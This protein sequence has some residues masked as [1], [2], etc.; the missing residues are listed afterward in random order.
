M[1]AMRAFHTKKSGSGAPRPFSSQAAR[2]RLGKAAR[3]AYYAHTTPWYGGV[4]PR[5][6]P[7]FSI[8]VP[9][10][11]YARFLPETIRSLAAQEYD[12]ME[13]VIVNDGSPDNTE[14]VALGLVAEKAC[15]NLRYIRQENQGPAS[16]RNTGIAATGGQWV[17]S[18][19]SDDILAPGF[20]H[21]VAAYLAENDDVDAVSGAYRE[22]GARQ[23]DWKLTR[24][25]PERFLIQGNI[26]HCTVHRRSLWEAVGGYSP[27]N[28]WGGED[29]HFW[30]KCQVRGFRFAALPVPML[31]YRIHEGHSRFR[32]ATLGT[33]WP[34][35]LAMHHT[36]TP[37]AYPPSTLRAAHA[38]LLGMSPECEAAIR[39]NLRRLP[40]L[41]APRFWLGLA[42]EGRG[43][44][45]LAREAY[46]ACLEQPWVGA[47][48]AE[49]RLAGLETEPGEPSFI[50]AE[51]T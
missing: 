51:G 11:N 28:P 46:R 36:M 40:D 4:M 31:H 15:P 1:K 16:A 45:A 9:C 19:D 29:W 25:V 3:G 2:F 39:H 17:M 8:V 22:F 30:I 14:E 20:L 32:E 5:Y 10:Y 6:R 50:D 26:M 38:T 41:I 48:Q 44:Y 35:F 43:E 47:W 12:A 23:S 27:D 34:E 49:D 21:A 33:R 42:H 7:L 37:E 13:V 18:L 24:Y